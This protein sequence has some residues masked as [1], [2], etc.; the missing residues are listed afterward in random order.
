MHV[1]LATNGMVVDVFDAEKPGIWHTI[2]TDADAQNAEK[3]M[4]GVKWAN[5]ITLRTVLSLVIHMGLVIKT[6]DVLYAG[7]SG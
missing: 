3:S 4:T 5:H 2:G 7:K 1:S 6:K